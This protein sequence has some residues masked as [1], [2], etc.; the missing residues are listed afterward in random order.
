M[1][2]LYVTTRRSLRLQDSQH[3]KPQKL[4]GLY[5]VINDKLLYCRLKINASGFVC[6]LK[7]ASRSCFCLIR[8]PQASD[9][10]PSYDQSLSYTLHF[11]TVH[12]DHRPVSA[13]CSHI[14]GDQ[15]YTYIK[16]W[17][18]TVCCCEGRCS[19]NAGQH[20]QGAALRR[21]HA[22]LICGA[23]GSA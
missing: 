17:P 5:G 4:R 20:S 8:P 16:G 22:L 19:D 15:A 18:L 2:E 1:C 13:M 11:S 23:C 21:S 6:W 14:P 10:W 7:S 9:L 3:L 12:I